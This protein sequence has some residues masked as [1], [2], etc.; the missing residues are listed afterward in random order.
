MRGDRE[1]LPAVAEHAA[2]LSASTLRSSLAV[3][4]MIA[5]AGNRASKRFLDFFAAAIKTVRHPHGLLPGRVLIYFPGSTNT[6]IGEFPDIEPVHVAAYLKALKVADI[7]NPVAILR[8]A[9]KPTVKQHLAAIRMLF[10]WLVVGQ[11]RRHQ[12]GARSASAEHVVRRGKTPV[13]T[14]Q[15]ARHLLASIAVSRKATLSDRS[16]AEVPWLVGPVAGANA[17]SLQARARPK[18]SR[19]SAASSSGSTT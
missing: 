12:S 10:D 14:K 5:N 19:T 2:A 9:S 16:E 1:Q 8:A 7:C 13:L 18:W 11:V 17:Q 6:P 4:V 3:P 15:Q